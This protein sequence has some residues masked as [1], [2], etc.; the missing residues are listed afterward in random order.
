MNIDKKTVEALD[1]RGDL[2]SRK[3]SLCEDAAE[4]AYDVLRGIPVDDWEVA[5]MEAVARGD[6]DLAQKIENEN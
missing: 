4:I 6:Y 1:N 2:F 3:A 5:F